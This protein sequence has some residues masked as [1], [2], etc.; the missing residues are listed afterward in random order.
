MKIIA[1]SVG[2]GKTRELLT[3]AAMDHAQVL[4]TNKR[5][6]QRK[7][8]AY[9]IIGLN[10]IDWNDMMYDDYDRDKP[11]YIH[12]AQDVMEELFDNDFQVKLLGMSVTLE[13]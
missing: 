11:L 12:K 5:A 1:R 3:A 7:A 13:D 9:G 10:I 6:L 4:T 2:T 8:E